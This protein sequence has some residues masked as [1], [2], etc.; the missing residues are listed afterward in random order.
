MT[1]STTTN[2]ASFAGNG[3][4]VAFSFPYTFTAQADLVVLLVT[5]ATGASVTKSLTTHYT[6]SGTVD[7]AGRY[8][9]GGTVTMLTAPTSLETLVIYRDPAR[10]QSLDLVEND[11]LPAEEVE[12]ALDK[13]TLI[14]QRVRDLVDRSFT[15]ADS[16]TSGA[17]LVVPSPAASNL[18]GWNAAADGL[19]NYVIADLTASAVTAFADTILATASEATFKALVNLEIGTDVQAYDATLASLAGLTLSQGC[20]LTATGADAGAVLAKGTASQQLRMNSGATAPEWFTPTAFTLGTPAASTSGVAVD[21]TGIPSGA[22]RITINFSSVSTNGTSVWQVQ[23]GDAGGIEASGYVGGAGNR[24]AEST[25]AAGFAVLAASIAASAYSG[26][27]A[28]SLEN[29]TSFTWAEHGVL[30][31]DATGQPNSSA[32]AKSL[33]AELDRVRITTVNGTDAFDAGEINIS[34][35][36]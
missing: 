6:I 19:T 7:S 11:P 26:S 2:R 1:V 32:G 21:F 5:N 34:Y 22:K 20:L 18:I 10:T 31:L 24:G 33:T 17:S 14:A 28:L 13:L 12:K 4:T 23:L 27:I 9:S 29:S 30:S 3:V 8:Q 35:E 16:D 15:L 36:F 25:S